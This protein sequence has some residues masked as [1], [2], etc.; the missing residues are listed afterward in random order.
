MIRLLILCTG[1]FWATLGFAYGTFGPVYEKGKRLNPNHALLTAK[2]D[3][4][5]AAIINQHLGDQGCYIL[6]LGPEGGLYEVT[7]IYWLHGLIRIDG[8]YPTQ[9]PTNERSKRF[10]YPDDLKGRFSYFTLYK[11]LCDSHFPSCNNY[12]TG[13][14]DTGGFFMNPPI[15]P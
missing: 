15:R 1:V 10:C 14:S 12:C 4:E 6:C 5:R 13:S 11:S 8:H 2:D 9:T 7:D 3:E